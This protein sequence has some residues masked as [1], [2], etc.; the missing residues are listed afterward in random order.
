MLLTKKYLFPIYAYMVLF[1]QRSKNFKRYLIHMY[2]YFT[3]SSTKIVQNSCH[4]KCIDFRTRYGCQHWWNSVRIWIWSRGYRKYEKW[5]NCSSNRFWDQI[6]A[7]KVVLST[8]LLLIFFLIFHIL[9]ND[10]KGIIYLVPC[11]RNWGFCGN[12]YL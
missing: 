12:R 9:L 1:A 6:N 8:L 10:I 5:R 2:I 7:V 4:C 11:N 3:D